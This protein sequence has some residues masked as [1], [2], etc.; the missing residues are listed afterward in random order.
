MTTF[1][2]A[3]PLLPLKGQD[4]AQ[5]FFIWK[6]TKY[7]YDPGADYILNR[8]RKVG[9]RTG[10]NSFGSQ[11][12]INP[13]KRLRPAR[14]W[15]GIKIFI[16]IFIFVKALKK[17]VMLSMVRILSIVTVKISLLGDLILP[18]C[19]HTALFWNLEGFPSP[20]FQTREY[21]MVYRG[22]GFLAAVWFGSSPP[23]LFSR[24]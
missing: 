2:S 13:I 18:L 17:S 8:N 23:P 22:Q 14:I 9:S 1:W 3:M 4:I 6:T 5:N 11:H 16:S 15:S 12:C 24:Q 7:C 21:W 20:I 10:I 19:N